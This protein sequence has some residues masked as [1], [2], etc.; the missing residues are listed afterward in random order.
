MNAQLPQSALDVEVKALL[1]RVASDRDERIEALRAAADSQAQQI[2]SAARA[3]AL[4]NVKK[5]VAQ[6]RASIDQGLKAAQARVDLETLRHEQQE[7]RALLEHMWTS[8]AG[9]IEQR[10]RDAGERRMWIEAALAQAGMLLA[11]RAWRIECGAGWKDGER[12]EL[13]A[14]ARYLGSSAIEWRLDPTLQAGLR[15]RA[16]RVCIDATIQGL[17]AAREDIE[18]AFLAEY[19]A[20]GAHEFREMPK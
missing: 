19:L 15:V 11:G 8:C 16:E 9:A 2:V 5:A 12:S 6:E 4:V 10:W 14:Q 17:L 1:E 20:A 13:E 3:E 7:S 18:S